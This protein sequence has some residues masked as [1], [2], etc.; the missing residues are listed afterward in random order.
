MSWMYFYNNSSHP[1]QHSQ[2]FCSDETHASDTDFL[3]EGQVHGAEVDRVVKLWQLPGGSA[4][5]SEYFHLRVLVTTLISW[6]HSLFM[7]YA[8]LNGGRALRGVS[9]SASWLLRPRLAPSTLSFFHW[10]SN[11]S[12]QPGI[13]P[14]QS[15]MD[16]SDVRGYHIHMARES[17]ITTAVS[18]F[19]SAN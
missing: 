14:R 18:R 9:A 15:V 1:A 4:L 5:A 19:C 16:S 11:G 10:Q 2:P 6:T 13:S 17:S 3:G 7:G 12:A 8:G